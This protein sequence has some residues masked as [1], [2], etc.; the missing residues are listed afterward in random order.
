MMGQRGGTQ[1]KLFYSFSLDDHVPR[2]H[3]LRGI[4]ASWI[5]VTCASTLRPSTA[6]Q[7]VPPSIRS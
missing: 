2:D 3:L 1:D 7:A 5:S 4:D 6:T